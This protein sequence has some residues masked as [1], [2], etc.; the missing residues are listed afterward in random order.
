M[1]RGRRDSGFEVLTSS[2]E[3]A[4]GRNGAGEVSI[5]LKSAQTASRARPMGSSATALDARNFFAPETSRCRLRRNQ[6]GGSIGGRS[7][8][9]VFF[10]ADYEGTRTTKASR[11]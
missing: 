9:T 6:F 11:R 5:V 1:R 8:K 7:R 2:Y 10:F 3:T 4:F